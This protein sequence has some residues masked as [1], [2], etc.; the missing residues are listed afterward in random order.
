[1]CAKKLQ[2]KPNVYKIAFRDKQVV[3][4]E[5]KTLLN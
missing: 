5:Q 2:N 3:K 1:M 4:Y